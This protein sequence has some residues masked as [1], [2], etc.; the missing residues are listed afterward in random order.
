[1]H[2]QA[3][4]DYALPTRRTVIGGMWW[5]DVFRLQ[6]NQKRIS[7]RRGEDKRAIYYKPTAFEPIDTF[8][9]ELRIKGY[10]KLAAKLAERPIKP[11]E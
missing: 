9:S 5:T 10:R 11:V 6:E 1:V 4:N 7:G 3:I 2:V 8:A